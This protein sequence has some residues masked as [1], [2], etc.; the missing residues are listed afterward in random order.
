M[1]HVSRMLVV[2][3][4][5]VAAQAQAAGGLLGGGAGAPGVI[6]ALPVPGVLQSPL[7]TVNRTTA[8]LAQTVNAQTDSVRRD[9]V[10][11]TLDTR[12]VSRDEHG[13]AIVG[14][15]VLA[16]SPSAVSLAIARRLNFTIVRQDV[17][18]ALG[19]S[20]VTL[21]APAA[22]SAPQGL[23]ALRAADPAGAYDYAHIYNPSGETTHLEA[24]THAQAATATASATA[25]ASVTLNA[26][27]T[28]KQRI[29]RISIGMID[30][31]VQRHHSALSA[32]ALVTQ[33]FGSDGPSPPSEHG[34]AVASL[35]VG[36]D[37]GFSGYLAGAKLYAADVFGGAPTG[38]TAADIARALNWLAVNQVPVTNVSLTGPPNALL[39]AAVKAFI[40]SGHV[41]VAAV[42]ND[43]PAAPPN[44]PAAYEGVIGVSSVDATHHP[45]LD[46]N[47]AA[48]RF[49][50][51]GVDVKAASLPQGYRM[52]TG[53]S[54]AAPVVTARFA[55]IM[56]KPDGD[57]ARAALEQL[58][59]AATRLP[60]GAFGYLAPPGGALTAAIR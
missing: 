50:A 29:D 19:I 60:A 9:I 51:L 37:R 41:L 53:T 13:A 36:K 21:H 47:S 17:L 49:A 14:N 43:G 10:G 54:Y 57:A 18:N 25:S 28:S 39:A 46:A 4:L 7:S 1:V 27:D 34:T 5:A 52:L 32:V 55:L 31:G 23:A 8:A 2:V 20:I 26:A 33:N 11:R 22:M 56:L 12:A 6:N 44:Y 59:G 35:L 16:V 30:G 38:G 58:L 40:A 42:G 15:E 24:A 48:V 3:M 45:Q